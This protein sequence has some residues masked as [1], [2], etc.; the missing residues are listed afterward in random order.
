MA[1]PG[2]SL[3]S[4]SAL[5]AFNS[6]AARYSTGDRVYYVAKKLDNSKWERGHG[7]YTVGT[8]D[9]LTRTVLGSSQGDALINWLT[10]DLTPVP[11]IVY[12]APSA[13]AINAIGSGRGRHSRR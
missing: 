1:F 11:Y 3:S 13:E 7:I 4:G 8:P 12:V 2:V 6:L 9:T 5:G 10:G